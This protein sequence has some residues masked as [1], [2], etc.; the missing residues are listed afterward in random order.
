MLINTLRTSVLNEMKK[1]DNSVQNKLKKI[2]FLTYNLCENCLKKTK[3]TIGIYFDE[4][5]AGFIL[6]NNQEIKSVC[7]NCLNYFVPKIYFLEEDQDDLNLKELNFLSPMNLIEKIDT[8]IKSRGEISFYKENEWSEIYFNIIF[9]F[10]LF[11][12]PNCVLYVQNKMSKF[13]KIKNELKENRNRKLMSKEKEKEKKKINFFFQKFN[14]GGKPKPGD[15]VSNLSFDKFNS[16]SNLSTNNISDLSFTSNGKRNIFMSNEMDIWRTY[17]LK[18][19]NMKTGVKFFPG[20]TSEKNNVTQEDKN[21]VNSKINETRFFLKDIINYF[22]V[23]SQEKLRIFLEKYDKNEN[24]KKNDFVNMQLKKENDKY[25]LEQSLKNSDKFSINA[26]L[27]LKINMNDI[28]QIDRDNNI[29][30]NII[31]PKTEKQPLDNLSKYKTFNNN[32]INNTQNQISNIKNNTQN[33]NANQYIINNNITKNNY[34]QIPNNNNYIYNHANTTRV[35]NNNNNNINNNNV[36]VNTNVNN[37]IYQYPKSKYNDKILK[38]PPKQ[39]YYGNVFNNNI[40]N[41]Q[42]D[43]NEL[44][45]KQYTVRQVNTYKSI[46]DN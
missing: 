20:E 39:N 21:E 3:E 2:I 6:K 34:N 45:K 19:L 24:L 14:R 12:L 35:W 44:R 26:N 43:L 31:N 4:I 27:N 23:N 46:Y 18:K 8:I 33:I 7:S 40:N 32:I 10:E 38:T 17:Q 28:K 9:Y 36:N 37:A 13:E 16:N 41:N 22:C 1:T 15:H 25:A 5:L 29:I 30:K 42:N 11:D